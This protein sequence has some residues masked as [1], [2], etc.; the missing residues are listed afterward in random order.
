MFGESFSVDGGGP[1]VVIA[2]VVLLILIAMVVTGVILLVVVGKSDAGYDTSVWSNKTSWGSALMGV[3]LIG[4]F[5]FGVGAV[6]G[7]SAG[8]AGGMKKL[9]GLSKFM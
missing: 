5:T 2:V 4:L 1:Q 6:V 8:L 9:S 7:K 3:G